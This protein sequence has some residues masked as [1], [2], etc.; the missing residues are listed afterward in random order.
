[1]REKISRDSGSSLAKPQRAQRLR[2]G[3]VIGNGRL[4]GKYGYQG[5]CDLCGLARKKLAIVALPS[6]SRREFSRRA[7]E[8][9]PLIIRENAER[10]SVLEEVHRDGPSLFL[11]YISSYSIS[12]HILYL[13][14]RYISTTSPHRPKVSLLSPHKAEGRSAISASHTYHL[15]GSISSAALR[16]KI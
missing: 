12:P 8:L 5:L 10:P 3:L 9:L 13:H 16:E 4:R 6:Q 14:I 11:R 2:K 7:A 1:M 15:R